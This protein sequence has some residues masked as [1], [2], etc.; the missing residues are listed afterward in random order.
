MRNLQLLIFLNLLLLITGI[1]ASA[2]PGAKRVSLEL[3]G[4]R[5]DSLVTELETQTGYHF[6]YDPAQFDS[7]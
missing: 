6:Y 7:L 4:A 1:T 3:K 5:I 2:Q